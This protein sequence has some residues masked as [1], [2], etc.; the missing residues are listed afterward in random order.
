MENLKAREKAL[1]KGR[2]ELDLQMGIFAKEKKDW[3]IA[4]NSVMVEV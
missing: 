2:E 3:E 1:R 4:K